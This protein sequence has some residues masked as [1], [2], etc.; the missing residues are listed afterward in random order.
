MQA[1]CPLRLR[2][3]KRKRILQNYQQEVQQQQQQFMLQ[4][5]KEM[6]ELK[7]VFTNDKTLVE[8]LNNKKSEIRNEYKCKK[9]CG[10]KI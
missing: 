7:E 8:F 5:D 2:V 3:R 6:F 4:V 10:K 9:Y 1:I